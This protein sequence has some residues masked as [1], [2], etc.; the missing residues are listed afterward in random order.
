MYA[1]RPTMCHG[2]ED[3]S[4]TFD[5]WE[6]AERH[7]RSSGCAEVRLVPSRE[8][9]SRFCEA[10]AAGKPSDTPDLSN[11]IVGTFE[12]VLAPDGAGV[13]AVLEKSDGTSWRG[14]RFVAAD[15]GAKEGLAVAELQA[16]RGFQEHACSH[17]SRM[18]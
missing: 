2:A 11:G 4:G 6:D 14:S 10:G 5:K 17:E 8:E 3:S 9:A 13:G 12:W 1:V 16:R 7:L 15:G 18:S